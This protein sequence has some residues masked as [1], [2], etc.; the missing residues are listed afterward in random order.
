MRSSNFNHNCT[1]PR[2][3]RNF[4]ENYAK[5]MRTF[6][7]LHHFPQWDLDSIILCTNQTSKLGPVQSCLSGQQLTRLRFRENFPWLEF[8]V[9]YLRLKFIF[10]ISFALNWKCISLAGILNSERM[11]PLSGFSAV[12]CHV[13]LSTPGWAR[14]YSSH[15]RISEPSLHPKFA[16]VSCHG[17]QPTWSPYNW[18][19][20]PRF[21]LL[22]LYICLQL[23]AVKS[24]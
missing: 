17:G 15:C 22:Y 7:N 4:Q 11:Y 9:D 20:A 21:N 6:T 12:S 18:S 3:S 5:P 24:Q 2:R 8:I 23:L 14:V 1:K 16:P 13:P 19:K 10:H